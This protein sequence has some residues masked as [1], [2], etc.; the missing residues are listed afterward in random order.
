MFE[1]R[2]AAAAANNTC[3][4]FSPLALNH[5]MGGS[6]S[7]A[8][9]NAFPFRARVNGPLAFEGG[10]AEPQFPWQGS[11][12]DCLA[13]VA[14]EIRCVCARVRV[15]GEGACML[16]V[17]ARAHIPHEGE[18]CTGPP[19]LTCKHLPVEC[20]ALPQHSALTRVSQTLQKPCAALTRRLWEPKTPTPATCKHVHTK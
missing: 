10:V 4:E 13:L 9:N 3:V 8:K 5:F 20:I 17:Y 16:R 19:A 12:E 6:A 14:A 15:R 7:E 2:E 18:R 11:A 1:A